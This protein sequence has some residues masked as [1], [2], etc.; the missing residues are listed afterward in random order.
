MPG[1]QILLFALLGGILPALFWL[2]FWLREDR[3]HPE[4]RSLII[5]AFFG[6]G[7]ATAAAFIVEKYINGF[8]GNIATVVTYYAPVVEELAKLAIAYVLV[9]R[10]KEDDEPVDPVIYMITVAL[11]FAA[12][13]NTL[14]LFSPLLSGSITDS[15]I[16]ANMRFMGAALLHIV[17]SAIIGISIG[18]SFYKA[19]AIRVASILAGLVAGIGLHIAFNFFIMNVN[20]GDTFRQTLAV[21]SVL[22]V[23]VILLMLIFE[24]IKKIAPR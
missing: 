19:K 8:I 16:T 20:T 6:G 18:A 13:E 11:G 3:S 12:L 7:L 17:A 21:F 15:I 22:W 9:L 24:R 2:W 23:A 10:R 4:P 5:L 1:P 14:F